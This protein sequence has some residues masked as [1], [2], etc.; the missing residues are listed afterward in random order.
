MLWIALAWGTKCFDLW[1]VNVL[2]RDAE[3]LAPPNVVLRFAQPSVGRPELPVL[4]DME[5]NEVPA[6]LVE[7]ANYVEL[8]PLEPLI[9]GV[10]EIPE[11]GSFEVGGPRD[12]VPPPEPEFVDVWKRAR[13]GVE[14]TY[15]EFVPVPVEH[16]IEIQASEDEA[17]VEDV[18]TVLSIH[19]AT[20]S[21]HRD[22]DC[23]VMPEGYEHS[24]R[25]YIRARTVDL[26]GNA[27]DWVNHEPAR[28]RCGC[29]ASPGYEGGPVMLLGL[30]LF[31]RRSR[32]RS[33]PHLGDQG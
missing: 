10:Y 9:E 4:H 22:P 26:A 27:S 25:Y 15:F 8:W 11:Q 32:R 7:E 2:E 17:F 20:T 29:Q 6:D 13:N 21:F 1:S 19:G 33:C 16:H 12:E 31:R 3:I 24:A 14:W 28:V 18:H 5:G 23:G 30:A